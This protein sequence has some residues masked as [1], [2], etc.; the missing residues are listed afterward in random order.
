LGTGFSH[1][2]ILKLFHF[3][4]QI[5]ILTNKM[6]RPFFIKIRITDAPNSRASAGLTIRIFDFSV[7]LGREENAETVKI[8]SW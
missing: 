1:F 4:R 3:L 7:K 8:S 6:H 5:D 2:R